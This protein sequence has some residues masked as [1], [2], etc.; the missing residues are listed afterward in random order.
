MFQLAATETLLLD[1][2]GKLRKR[3]R[4]WPE[5]CPHISSCP[6]AMQRGDS[7]FPRMT[8]MH[9]APTVL[10]EVPQHWMHRARMTQSTIP[11]AADEREIHHPT[12][13]N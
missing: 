2:R 4:I 1:K 5:K 9:R 12:S 6:S 10:I 13:R 11:Q 8:S 7:S 3:C